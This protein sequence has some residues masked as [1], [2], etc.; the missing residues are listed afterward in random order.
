MLSRTIGKPDSVAENIKT[1]AGRNAV[2]RVG[3]GAERP[4]RE[5]ACGQ[6]AGQPPAES[7][8][9]AN[10]GLEWATGVTRER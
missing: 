5:G 9:Q 1:I 4:V 7:P 8:T 10:T 3:T 2:V 6:I